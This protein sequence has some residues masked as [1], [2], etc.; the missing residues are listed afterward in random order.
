MQ[1]YRIFGGRCDSS[2]NALDVRENALDIR[3]HLQLNLS[4]TVVCPITNR[5][6]RRASEVT[7]ETL[8]RE[9]RVKDSMYRECHVKVIP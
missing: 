8:F 9:Y 7:E 1:N 3:L 2:V 4:Q 5:G 6:H